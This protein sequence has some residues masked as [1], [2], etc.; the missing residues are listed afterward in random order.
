MMMKV[1]GGTV[2]PQLFLDKQWLQEMD[3]HPDDVDLWFVGVM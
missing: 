1:P 3:C 2:V